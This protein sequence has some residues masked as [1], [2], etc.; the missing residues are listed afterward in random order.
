MP[1][2]TAAEFKVDYVQILDEN[3]NADKKLM[4]KISKETV[5]KI[6]K[7][8]MQARRFDEKLLA[9]QRQGRIGTFAQVKGQEAHVAAAAAI[10][11]D[12]WMIP[13]FRE[14]GAQLYRGTPMRNVILVWGGDERGNY[15]PYTP[16]DLPMA[17][18]V[19]SQIPHAMGIAW[20]LKLKNKKN[21]AL[22]FFGDGATS[23][24]DF[25]EALNFAGVMNA[26]AIFV[27]Q[28]NQYAISLPV[29]KQTA[30]KTLAQKAIDA[31]IEGIKIDGND[32]LAMYSVVD[33]ARNKAIAG[34]GPTLIEMFTYRMSD[35]TTADD[36]SK[37]REEK[38][39]KEWE[40][41]DPIERFRKFLIKE[42]ILTEKAEKEIMKE[43]EK[44]IEKEVVAAENTPQPTDEDMFKYV[45]KEMN[46][47]QKEQLDYIKQFK[48]KHY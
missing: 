28:N 23:E 25:H 26:P 14:L 11:K 6:Y 32:V 38:E 22:C 17:I 34:K 40:K 35:H 19:G 2:K 24:G 45:Y 21:V 10:T 13:S 9:L 12:D 42:K 41:K 27:C 1:R 5:L 43:I 36:A 16:T 8:M 29:A 20:G 4:P 33:Y 39:V 44:E 46:D 31:G 37:Y 47:Y 3:G 30:S 18:P 48:E 7:T 15:S